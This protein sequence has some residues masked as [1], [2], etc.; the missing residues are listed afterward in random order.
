LPSTLYSCPEPSGRGITRAS[1]YFGR[2]CSATVIASAL[3]NRCAQVLLAGA[4]VTA[5]LRQRRR[6]RKASLQQRTEQRPGTGI[7][8]R[9]HGDTARTRVIGDVA[10]FAQRA[11]PQR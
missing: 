7:I 4:V 5:G 3:L 9:R 2:N 11:H 6:L 8:V 1:G 10:R